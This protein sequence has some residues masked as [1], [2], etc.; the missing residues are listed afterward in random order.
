MDNDLGKSDKEIN[1][2]IESESNRQ[3]NVLTLIASENITSKAV[4]EATSS[5]LTNKYS[6]GYPNKRYYAGNEFIDKVEE[7]AISRLKNLF[8]AEHA[9]VQPHAGSPANL[10][11]YFALLDYKDK[12]LSMNLSHGGHLTHGSPVNFS[13]KLYNFIFYGVDE[14]TGMI[15]MEKVRETA[16]KEKPKMIIAGAS[17]YPREIDFKAFKEIADEISAYFMVDMAHIAGL[18]AAKL[19]SDPVPYADVVTST[20]HKT[21]RG[22]RSAFIL[23][24]EKFSKKIDKA[25]FP[26]LQGGPMDHLTAAKAVCFKEAMTAEFNNYQKQVIK[27]AKVLAQTLMEYK[28]NLVSDGT[29]NHLMLVDLSNKQISGGEAQKMLEKSGI[30]LNK[31]MVPFDKRSPLDPSGIRIGTP[32]MTSRGMKE[33]EAQLIGHYISDVIDKKEN[34][35]NKISK[36][37]KDFPV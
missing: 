34:V 27:N 6:E 20:T 16:I 7:I 2:L 26:G 12:I 31:N 4:L 5:V 30:I 37:L 25:V 32:L 13:G 23:S 36:L 3:S 21:L 18:I 19:H 9:N 1:R 33:N 35:K 28:F 24:K 14:K 10:A 22:P 8:G 11:A 17:A 29:D 15:D